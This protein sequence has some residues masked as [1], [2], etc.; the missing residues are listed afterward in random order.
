MMNIFKTVRSYADLRRRKRALRNIRAMYAFFGKDVSD[1]T[2][3]EIEERR[4]SASA[5][6]STAGFT[7]QETAN[8]LKVFSLT[9]KRANDHPDAQNAGTA[10]AGQRLDSA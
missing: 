3:E 1:L 2:D 5:V 4:A 6:F 8:G 9:L 7:A 10:G